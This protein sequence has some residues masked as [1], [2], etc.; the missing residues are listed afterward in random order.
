MYVCMNLSISILYCTL[1][2]R[3]SY[4]PSIR[5][6]FEGQFWKNYYYYYYYIVLYIHIKI[7]KSHSIEMQTTNTNSQAA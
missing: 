6:R 5:R 4:I 1:Y 2:F 3:L 7:T